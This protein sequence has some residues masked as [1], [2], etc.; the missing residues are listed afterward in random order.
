[1]VVDYKMF[2]PYAPKFGAGLLFVLEQMPLVAF[3]FSVATSIHFL[4]YIFGI[5]LL[6]V[7]FSA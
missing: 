5:F 7:Y 6:C 3:V 4:M 1:M 2:V